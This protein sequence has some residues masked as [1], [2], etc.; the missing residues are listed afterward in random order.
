MR[1]KL[2]TAEDAE[3]EY[4][5]DLRSRCGGEIELLTAK[6]VAQA[7]ADGNE[8]AR[9]VLAHACQALGWA[10][11]QAITLVSPGVVVV[12]GGVSLIEQSLFLVPLRNE[13]DRY[14]FPPLRGSFRVE[15]AA[16]GE[17]AVVYGALAAAAQ[18]GNP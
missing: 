6:M 9:E 13:I 5:A 1:K 17:L 2:I 16:L 3:E 12:G 11:A 7:A 18:M 4:V 8:I 15:P 14:V 10:I